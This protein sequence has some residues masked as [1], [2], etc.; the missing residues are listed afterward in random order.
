M[1][2]KDDPGVIVE[3]CAGA[4]PTNRVELYVDLSDQQIRT[5]VEWII[6]HAWS[7]RPSFPKGGVL[8]FSVLRLLRSAAL[9]AQ[10]FPFA[11]GDRNE[12]YS[13]PDRVSTPKDI[14]RRR[15]GG[16]APKQSP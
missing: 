7:M 10:L 13:P 1:I 16:G 2:G 8:R 11:I 9:S 12:G 3:G 15:S 4:H 5:A 6:R 14:R